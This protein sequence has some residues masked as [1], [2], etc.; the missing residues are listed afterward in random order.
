MI[1]SIRAKA[2]MIMIFK[3]NSLLS[4]REPPD[5]CV[6]LHA[7]NLSAKSFS[8]LTVLRVMGSGIGVFYNQDLCARGH[9]DPVPDTFLYIADFSNF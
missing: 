5:L 6:T 7:P 4:G 8:E 2:Y 1:V 3:Q 9:I